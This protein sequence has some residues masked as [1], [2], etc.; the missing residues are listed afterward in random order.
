MIRN[1]APSGTPHTYNDVDTY[2]NLITHIDGEQGAYMG[3][4][5]YRKHFKIPMDYS[6]RKNLHRI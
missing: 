4:A 1:G 5:W 2:R 3:R 6:D